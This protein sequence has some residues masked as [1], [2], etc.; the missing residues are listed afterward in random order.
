MKSSLKKACLHHLRCTFGLDEYRPGQREAVQAVLSG[1][2]VLCILPTGAGKS[3]CWQLPAV[4]HGGMTVVISPL[5]ALMRDQVQ[6]LTDI[7]IPAVSLDSLM[8]PEEKKIAFNRIRQGSIRIVFVSPERL[9]Q[10]GF[11]RLCQKMQPWLVVVDE[12]H[13]MVQWG[14]SFRPAYRGIADYIAELPVRP[15]ICAMTATADD[16]MQRAIRDQLG[17]RRPRQVLLP[18][19][20]ENLIHEVHTTLDRTREIN[21][22]LQVAAG[23][24]VIFC[25]SRART[26]RLCERL[27]ADG[28]AAVFYHAGMGR[29][30]RLQVQQDFVA[31][32]TDVLCATSAFGLGVDIPDIRLVIHDYLPDDLIDYVQQTGRAGRDGIAARCI[33]LLEPNDLVS[34]AAIEKRAKERFKRKPIR[35]WRFLRKKRRELR[36]VMKVLM[37]SNCIPAAATRD[38]GHKAAPCGRCSACLYGRLL[39]KVPSLVGMKEWQIRMWILLWQREALAMRQHCPPGE[40]LSDA[41]IRWGAKD[42]V[43]PK[44]ASVRPEMERMLRHFRRE[45]MHEIR[46]ERI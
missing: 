16:D 41:A 15:V 3:L 38:F 25:R 28:I 18:I 33:L 45:N 7:G 43:F 2:D 29:E 37:A 6:H 12:A 26:E 5:I 14:E 44:D 46:C 4:V 40:I 13:C 19:L 36:Q 9:V 23:K 27:C 17:M 34:K 42:Y 8:S 31:G 1:R 39:D 30:E 21:R 35:R 11:R 32:S 10:P 22:Q 24:T 20:R